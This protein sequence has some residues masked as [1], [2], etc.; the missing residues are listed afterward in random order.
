MTKKMNKPIERIK[1]L[2]DQLATVRRVIDQ[3]EKEHKEFVEEL[4]IQ[5]DKIQ[6]N[7]LLGLKKIGLTSIK[8][9]NGETCAIAKRKGVEVTSEAH[10]LSWAMANR[11][12]S[13]NK[14]LV[15]Q[16]LESVIKTGKKL[17]D[18]FAYKEV[19][20]ISVRKPKSEGEAEAPKE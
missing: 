17:P 8:A 1:I 19:E 16:K 2:A 20:Y 12:V 15:K 13:I 10:A 5:R 18:G 9:E 6:D 7:L 11:A 3:K 4:K 14:I